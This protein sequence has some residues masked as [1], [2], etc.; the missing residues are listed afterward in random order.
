[1]PHREI[2]NAQVLTAFKNVVAAERE[3]MRKELQQFDEELQQCRSAFDEKLQ[4]FRSEVQD[5]LRALVEENSKL[6][7]E[8]SKLQEEN[9]KLR[10]PCA[11]NFT[12]QGV[13]SISSRRSATHSGR[14]NDASGASRRARPGPAAELR[15]EM[16]QA[17]KKEP[18]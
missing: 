11:R 12:K 17:T 18:P 1:M 13:C 14:H 6:Q 5:E 16:G 7:E 10:E 4:Q 9:S 15:M 2:T 8:N 3:C